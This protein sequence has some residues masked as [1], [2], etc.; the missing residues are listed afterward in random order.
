MAF[1]SI[2]ESTKPFLEKLFSGD[3]PTGLSRFLGHAS[4]SAVAEMVSCAI[5]NPAEVLKQNAQMARVDGLAARSNPVFVVLKKLGQNPR[6]MWA[7]YSTLLASRLPSTSLIFSLFENVK[8]HLDRRFGPAVEVSSQVKRSAFAGGLAAAVVSVVFVPIDVVKTRMRLM[9][10]VSQGLSS[11]PPRGV[12]PLSIT[13]KL[14]VTEGLSGFFRGGVLTCVAAAAGGGL[15]L[16]C[17]DGLKMYY[18]QEMPGQNELV[19]E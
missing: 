4:S 10:V 14:W 17:Y 12:T 13:R 9:A 8:D 19:L 18:T 5:I 11:G 3:E 16:G 15:Y 6:G 2:Y 7:G 1:F